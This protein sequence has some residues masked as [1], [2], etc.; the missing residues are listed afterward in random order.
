LIALTAIE[1]HLALLHSDRD[2][3]AMAGAVE[4]LN[5]LNSL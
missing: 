4:D 1:Y 2:F 5:I 3:D